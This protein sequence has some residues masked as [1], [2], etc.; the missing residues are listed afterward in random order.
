MVDRQSVATAH[1]ASREEAATP[2]PLAQAVSRAALP[3]EVS[4]PIA[5]PPGVAMPAA[6]PADDPSHP[7]ADAPVPASIRVDAATATTLA[8]PFAPTAWQAQRV[9]AP[10]ETHAA[11]QASTGFDAVSRSA[12]GA[13]PVPDGAGSATT[14]HHM[15]LPLLSPTPHAPQAT[16]PAALQRIVHAEA[17]PSRTVHRAAVDPPAMHA[18]EGRH[19]GA[20]APNPAA[21]GGEAA[22]AVHARAASRAQPV[23]TQAAAALT[24]RLPAALNLAPDG[25]PAVASALPQAGPIAATHSGGGL[26]AGGAAAFIA[27]AHEPAAANRPEADAA[28]SPAASTIAE[29]HVPATSTALPLLLHT[30]TPTHANAASSS[31]AAAEPPAARPAPVTL[32]RAASL[33]TAPLHRFPL[34]LARLAGNA[35]GPGAGASATSHGAPPSS[36]VSL[37]IDRAE[38]VPGAPHELLGAAPMEAAPVTPARRSDGSAGTGGRDAPV[39]VDDLVERAWQALMLR[40]VIEQERRGYGRWA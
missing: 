3:A 2:A 12:A 26:P 7:T 39:D 15:P 13:E 33:P 17:A 10:P 31:P 18:S 38:P 21:P 11:A 37:Q 19:D 20:D 1:R 30:P 36:A 9:A 28:A 29:P 40:L 6:A 4:M 24:L 27:R 23:I 35:A 5:H 34:A 16:A 14:P 32:A 25:A 8:T 22:A